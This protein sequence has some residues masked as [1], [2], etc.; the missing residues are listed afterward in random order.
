MTWMRAAKRKCG[1]TETAP[2]TWAVIPFGTYKGL[3]TPQVALRDPDYL[4]WLCSKSLYGVVG[5][6]VRDVARKAMAIRIPKRNPSRW[7][8]EY[9]F[10][11]DSKFVSLSLVAADSPQHPKWVE[12]LPYIDLSWTSRRRSYDKGGGKRLIRAFV[13]VYFGGRK[14]LTK[15]RCE[16]FFS[17]EKNF[18]ATEDW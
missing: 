10:D 14:R 6:Q 9:Q 16:G 7:L 18:V 11:R 1:S 17:N 3:T 15:K 2:I 12:R 13:S 4:Y 5:E 8:A